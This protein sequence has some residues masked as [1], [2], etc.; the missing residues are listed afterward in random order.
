MSY[1]DPAT[2]Q[3]RPSTVVVVLL[4]LLLLLLLPLLLPGG[5]CSVAGGDAG[6]GGCGAGCAVKFESQRCS[7]SGMQ[8]CATRERLWAAKLLD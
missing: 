2:L 3:E 8:V 4:L 6:G 1:L 5:T 7:G